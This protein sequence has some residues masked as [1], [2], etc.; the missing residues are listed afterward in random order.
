MLYPPSRTAILCELQMKRRPGVARQLL[1]ANRQ[2]LPLW[3]LA[4]FSKIW[5]VPFIFGLPD[6]L[7]AVECWCIDLG[8]EWNGVRWCWVVGVG[9]WSLQSLKK[10]S[11]VSLV[12]ASL[13]GFSLSPPTP[14]PIA[15][16]RE[17]PAESQA[18]LHAALGG[19]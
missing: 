18:D 1:V 9:W 16:G 6:Q 12:D 5:N 10:C 17:Q 7:Y 3:F 11:C 2:G 14:L 13:S 4:C 8:L 19:F 15:R